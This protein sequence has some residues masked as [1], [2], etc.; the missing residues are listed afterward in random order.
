MS[1]VDRCVER[2]VSR[3]DQCVERGVSRV[4]NVLREMCE[5]VDKYVEINTCRDL[6]SVLK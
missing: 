5:S 3:V 2:D 6:T 4:A 1:S